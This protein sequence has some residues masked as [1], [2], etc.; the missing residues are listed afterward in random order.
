MAP[1]A[2]RD[3][4]ASAGGERF[5]D[6]SICNSRRS[7]TAVRLTFAICHQSLG[8]EYRRDWLTGDLVVGV[9]LAA[10]AIPVSLA[11]AELA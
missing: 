5:L 4:I 11:Y 3:G 9:T 7:Q 2:R 1:V 6:R 10:Y 8:S